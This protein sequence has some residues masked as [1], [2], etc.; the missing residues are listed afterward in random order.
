M[1]KNLK[2]RDMQNIYF[3]YFVCK[4]DDSYVYSEIKNC[5]AQVCDL[6]GTNMYEKYGNDLN[7]NSI[8]YIPISGETKY[9]DE[10][11]K[12]WVNYFPINSDTEADYDIVRASRECDGIITL[13]CVSSQTNGDCLWIEHDNRICVL[14]ANFDKDNLIAYTKLNTY[15]PIDVDTNVWYRKPRDVSDTRCKIKFIEKS[16]DKNLLKIVFEDQNA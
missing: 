1:P 9:I 16:V 2:R 12:I 11:S 6:S 14:T 13:Y 4:D 10:V 5:S 7:Y 8:I 15:L 3:S